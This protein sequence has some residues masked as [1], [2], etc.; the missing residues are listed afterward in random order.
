MPSWIPQGPPSC[1]TPSPTPC[2]PRTGQRAGR[3]ASLGDWHRDQQPNGAA[4]REASEKGL[5]RQQASAEPTRGLDSLLL[6][7]EVG[8]GLV[9]PASGPDPQAVPK[10]I[11]ASFNRPP[12]GVLVGTAHVQASSTG[13]SLLPESCPGQDLLLP[14]SLH[15]PRV[16]LPAAPS[17]LQALGM[18]TQLLAHCS[19]LL[20]VA[21]LMMYRGKKGWGALPDVCHGV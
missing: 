9:A 12:G 3:G 16:L 14:L 4:G 8:P 15:R 19:L 10:G 11:D 5:P 6:F 13:P 1:S 18:K 2:L 7:L 21:Y 17:T 20:S